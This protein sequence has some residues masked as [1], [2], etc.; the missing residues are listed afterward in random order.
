MDGQSRQSLADVTLAQAPGEAE[1]AVNNSVAFNG[2]TVLG[3]R[4]NVISDVE[5]IVPRDMYGLSEVQFLVVPVQAA[6][7]ARGES[8]YADNTKYY[9]CQEAG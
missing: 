1:Y 6:E 5:G 7:P 4:I 2:L 9:Y 3:V 8:S